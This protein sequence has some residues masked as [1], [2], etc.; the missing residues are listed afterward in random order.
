MLV[1]GVA[2]LRINLF[3]D[4]LARLATVPYTAPAKGNLDNMMM[5]LTN[6][7]INKHSDDYEHNDHE[8]RDD[9][10]HKRSY[11]A[12]LKMLRQRHGNQA[13]DQM[14]HRI[15]EIIVKTV[16]IAQP[17]IYHLQRSC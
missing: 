7:A 9:V 14:V 17:N 15:N 6:Y 5:H 3:K 10:G 13:V 4:G 11:I 16:C 1:N 12:V 8:D 2:P